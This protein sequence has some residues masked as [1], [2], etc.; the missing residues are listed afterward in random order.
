M[1]PL[2]KTSYK[3]QICHSDDAVWH[4]SPKEEIYANKQ[5][6]LCLFEVAFR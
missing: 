3:L 2:E 1:A 5:T 4:A 6:L